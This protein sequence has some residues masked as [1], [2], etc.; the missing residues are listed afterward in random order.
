MYPHLH[1]MYMCTFKMLEIE[2]RKN[3]EAKRVK[4]QRCCICKRIEHDESCCNHR[5]LTKVF[6]SG[7]N[8]F[9]NFGRGR[10]IWILVTP[11]DRSI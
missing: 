8:T 1:C 4:T 9:I 3:I 5:F 10:Q 7:I 6:R 2:S 11:T